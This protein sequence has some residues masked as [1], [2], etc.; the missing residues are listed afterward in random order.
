ML[1]A[2]RQ[3]RVLLSVCTLVEVA[4]AGAAEMAFFVGEC[5]NPHG[6]SLTAAWEKIMNVIHGLDNSLLELGDVRNMLTGTTVPATDLVVGARRLSKMVGKLISDI[7]ADPEIQKVLPVPFL[8]DFAAAFP[9]IDPKMC[10]FEVPGAHACMR[11]L[12][13]DASK[14]VAVESHASRSA[15]D[16]DPSVWSSLP[17]H[18]LN[19]VLAKQPLPQLFLVPR[20]SKTWLTTSKTPGF[21]ALCADNPHTSKLFGI[22]SFHPDVEEFRLTAFD[23]KTLKWYHHA[24]DKVLSVSLAVN[25]WN[26]IFSHDGGL[27]CFVANNADSVVVGNPLT[28]LWKR[29]PLIHRHGKKVPFM[30]QLV[31]NVQSG[32]YEIKVVFGGRSVEGIHGNFAADVYNS[33]T[34]TWTTLRTGHVF[35]SQFALVF[36]CQQGILF[37]TTNELI[38][39]V[40]GD[41]ECYAAVGDSIFVMH[42]STR[43]RRLNHYDITEFAWESSTSSYSRRLKSFNCTLPKAPECYQ[44][45]VFASKRFIL[46]VANLGDT[47]DPYHNQIMMVC[48]PACEAWH[49]VPVLRCEPDGQAPPINLNR[50][51]DRAYSTNMLRQEFNGDTF[52]CDLRWDAFP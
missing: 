41:A 45:L 38:P 4:S 36:D 3:L 26:L 29:V 21:G 12:G 16:L 50:Q 32:F 5:S 17:E 18:L 7:K 27:V 24:L 19:L 47:Y 14:R 28:N 46:S 48:D 31:R 23:V 34:G 20:L 33:R 49:E 9:L 39:P 52:L 10:T 25:Y 37:E 40:E 8:E 35:A 1:S 6:G 15:F 22:V 11:R 43:Q 30:V 44:F 42:E 51:D 2:S 13:S